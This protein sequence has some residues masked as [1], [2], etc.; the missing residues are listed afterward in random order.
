MHG[1]PLGG[2]RRATFAVSVFAAI[3][4]LS[5]FPATSVDAQRDRD[6]EQEC[7]ARAIYHEARGEDRH[8]RLAVAHAVLNRRGQPQFKPTICEV[9]RQGA[10]DGSAGCQ[11]SWACD[12]KPGRPRNEEPHAESL[13]LAAEV[14]AGR[15]EDPT[16][17]AMWFHTTDTAPPSWTRELTR[18]AT[19]GN[20]V[21]Y[22]SSRTATNGG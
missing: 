17:G 11:F 6:D 4:A 16:G 10:A 13:A 9:I 1:S 18:T 5:L 20:H 22:K 21:F 2:L 14:L 7:L 19:F 3:V 15:T 8:G 12:G